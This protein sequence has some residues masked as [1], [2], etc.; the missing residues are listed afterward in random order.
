MMSDE[1]RYS[2]SA[3]ITPPRLTVIIPTQGRETLRRALVSIVDESQPEDVEIIVCADTH[4][5]L[6]SEVAWTARAFGA[7]YLE[8]DAG[9]HGYGHPQLAYAYPRA[10]GAWVAVLGDDDE[11][12]PGGLSLVRDV[13]AACADDPRPIIFRITM[14]P[15][16]SR[17]IAATMTIWREP[18]LACGNVSGQSIV[19]PNDP[20]KLAEYPPH[21]T[22]DFAFI[23]DTVERYG[24]RD[25]VVWRP[26]IL[27]VCH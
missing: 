23:R 21:S 26:E 27:C 1:G 18:D 11:F 25:R 19:L 8:H 10:S 2:R 13:A 17:R 3:R 12:V 14:E 20:S 24:G 9:H 6:L 4:G 5:P 22:G 7:V 16:A 15:S